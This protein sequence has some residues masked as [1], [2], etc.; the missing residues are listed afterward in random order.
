MTQMT[1]LTLFSGTPLS[2]SHIGTSWNQRHLCHVRHGEGVRNGER[3]GG[4][5]GKGE[6]SSGRTQR[7]QGGAARGRLR[8][9]QRAAIE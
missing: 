6:W 2:N 3:Q 8:G 7:G 4:K 1:H 9:G 5:H